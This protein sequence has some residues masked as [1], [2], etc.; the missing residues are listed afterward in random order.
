MNKLFML[1]IANIRKTKG[2]TISLFFLFFIAALLLNAGLLVSINF[3]SYF[4]QIT[5]ELNTSNIYYVM[6]RNSFTEEVKELFDKDSNVRL[7]QEEETIWTNAKVKYKDETRTSTFLFRDADQ[8]RELSRWKF[9]G[10]HL[11]PEEM[12]IYIP[13]LYQLE[14]GYKL[15][16]PFEIRFDD[17]TLTFTIKGFTEDIFFSSQDTGLLGVYLPQ[18]SFELV[19]QVLDDKYNTVTVFTDLREVNKDLETEIKSLTGLVTISNSSDYDNSILSFDLSLI[20]LSRTMMAS[21]VSAIFVVFSALLVIVCLIVVRF[22]IG[23]SIE[24][25]MTKIGSLKAM[26]YT[27]RQIIFSIVLQFLMIAFVGSILGISSSYLTTP[28][29]SDAFAGQSGLKWV[30]SFDGGISSFALCF[31]LSIVILV[32]YLSAGRIRKLHPIEALRGGIATH[33]FRKN[34]LPLSKAFG[35]LPLVLALKSLLQNKKQGLMITIILIGVSF[36]GAF[37][38]I[39]FYNTT[40]DTRAFEE[41][42]GIERSN[43]MAVFKPEV[44]SSGLVEKINHMEHVRKVQFIDETVVTLDDNEIRVYVME[45]YTNKETDTVYQGRYPLHSNEIAI[46]GLLAG[47]LD[48]TVG[49]MVT[50]KVG[51]NQSEFLITGLSQG[52]NMGGYNA[53]IRKDALM[54]LNPEFKQMCLQI[55]LDKGSDAGVFTEKLKEFYKDQLMIAIDM[56]TSFENGI[57]I[58]TSIVSKVGIAILVITIAVVILIL[59]FVINSS[60]TRK[61]RELGIQKAI[62]FTTLQLMNQISISFL[63]PVIAGVVIGCLLGAK[64]SNAIM[65]VSQRAMGIMKANYS[66]VPAWI[67]LF[68]IG[69]VV[70]SYAIS[71]LLAFKIRKISAYSLIQE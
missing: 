7:F 32:A 12:S 65:S 49:D 69:I 46:S 1:A 29:L 28:V 20:K 37:A 45:D 35:S 52:S 58:Y 21:M 40:F 26:G 24:D 56:D 4:E 23:N 44:D 8:N 11:E 51:E 66:I 34:H 30:Q 55:Y 5:K 17:I 61:K 60:V 43:A 27:A 36:A 70:L 59:Y 10:K 15:N 16:D 68:G 54:K 62:G 47:M 38:V 42:P 63:L 2:H 3:G 9:V 57:G 64:Q 19:N 25:D 67:A 39:M 48:K 71:M 14:A 13:Y 53:S 50:V 22:R 6:P 18:D 41:T 31:M 33:S